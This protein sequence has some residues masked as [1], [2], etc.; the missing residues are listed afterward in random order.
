MKALVE[1]KIRYSLLPKL[2]SVLRKKFPSYSETLLQLLANRDLLTS[3]TTEAELEALLN[4]DFETG[5]HD[6]WLMPNVKQ[7][8]KRIEAA[9]KA[10]ELITVYGDYD[11]D[12]IPGTAILVET[13]QRL[14]A[15]VDYLIP[16]RD[17]DGYGLS[18]GPIDRLID[19]G[20][21]L[22]ITV[23]CGIR[24]VEAVGYAKSKGIEAI[25]TDH[26]ELGDKL[27]ETIIVHPGLPKSKY[28]D[29]GLCGAGVAYKLAAALV[30][31]FP[32]KFDSGFL[33]WELDLVAISTVADVVPL[34][35]E[36]RVL[37]HY[38]LVVLRKTRRLGLQ[39]LYKVAVIE[40]EKIT[41][42]TVGF[43]I[44]PR[45]NAPGRLADAEDSLRLLLTKDE[46]EARRLALE[47]QRA[48]LER[49]DQTQRVLDE[50]IS[51][52]ESD[53]D[54]HIYV[55]AGPWP[56]GILGIVAGRLAEK[57][58]RPVIVIGGG[59][60]TLKGSARS[61]PELD[62]TKLLERS[63][64]ELIQCGGHPAAAGLSLKSERLQAFREL[65][66]NQAERAL[67]EV[68][69]RPS[70][71]VD[72]ELGFSEIVPGLWKDLCKL[73]PYGMGNPE[74]VFQA[75][76]EVVAVRCV[77]NGEKHLKLQLRQGEVVLDAIGFRM[78]GVEV[79][80]GEKVETIFKVKENSWNG[81]TKLE[82]QLVDILPT[83]AAEAV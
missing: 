78:G 68:D 38:G 39:A 32:D 43:G 7:A 55:L 37:A 45:I 53:P 5:L 73:E 8:V 42:V 2:S 70:R 27:P 49:Q 31:E 19:R 25:V 10:G 23:D 75:R 71:R 21:K 4:P 79:E 50:A 17:V 82:L 66:T 22:I 58:Y 60:E 15:K 52:V 56:T 83:K 12:G 11:A 62:I 54:K 46:K 67:V 16:A 80:V 65:I 77:G 18:N 13:L 20:T 6:P 35:G 3:K 59:G 76:A 61:I 64:K 47:L 63:A 48:N 74:P 81:S 57:Y 9:V 28:P 33:K 1:P 26:H 36:N 51:L 69:L 30:S 44:A 14:G 34:R 29:P 40:P 41:P 24:S 72:M